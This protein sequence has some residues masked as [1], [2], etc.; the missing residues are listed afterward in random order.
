MASD[1]T[2]RA[3]DRD[4]DAV[5]DVL[6]DAYVAGRLTLEEFDE[7]TAAT[8][9]GRTWGDL[10]GLTADL[11]VQPVLGTDVPGGALEASPPSGTPLPAPPHPAPPR[12]AQHG[13]PGAIM[14]FIMFWFLITMVTRSSLVAAV[15]VVILALVIVASSLFRRR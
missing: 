6:R 15:P 13:R 7:R 2:I 8:Y 1:Q 4:R 11:P 5:V 12:P 3:S 10:R 9:A 14:P